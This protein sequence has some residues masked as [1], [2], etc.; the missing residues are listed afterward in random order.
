M[1]VTLTHLAIGKK[2]SLFQYQKGFFTSNI[3]FGL[4]QLCIVK[5]YLLAIVKR[6]DNH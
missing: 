4:A 3:L 1:V 2:A 6:G 5:V